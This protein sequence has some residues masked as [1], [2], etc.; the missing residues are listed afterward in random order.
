MDN[1]PWYD[2][3]GRRLSGKPNKKGVYIREG[4]KYL[5]P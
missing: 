5:I 1:E 4:K 2:L 3:S